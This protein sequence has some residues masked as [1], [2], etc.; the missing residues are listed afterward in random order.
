MAT[1]GRVLHHLAS[2]LPDPK[3]TVLLV[4][5]QAEGTR[6]RQLLEGAPEVRIHGMPVAVR[7]RVAKINSMS[8]H[9]D[10][11][12]LVRW[13]KTLPAPPQ[14]LFL[15]HGEPGPM[16]ALKTTIKHELGWDAAT[17]QYLERVSL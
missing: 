3:N 6:G 5:F 7:A 9:A 13:L 15:V 16:D 1:G 12:E 4:G 10:R 8:A 17:P 2:A 11:S 14:R